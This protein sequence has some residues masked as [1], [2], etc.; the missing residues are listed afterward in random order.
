MHS[1][2][3]GVKE[4]LC[5]S[6]INNDP[7]YLRTGETEWAKKHNIAKKKYQYFQ[8]QLKKSIIGTP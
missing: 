3:Y 4:L 1:P 8:Y 7:N 2:I 6:V 5:L